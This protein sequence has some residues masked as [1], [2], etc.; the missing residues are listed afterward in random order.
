ME[1]YSVPFWGYL[2]AELEILGDHPNA[3]KQLSFRTSVPTDFEFGDEWEK[4]DE[5]MDRYAWPML[6][7][8]SKP[9]YSP[10]LNRNAQIISIT[11]MFRIL[12]QCNLNWSA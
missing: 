11:C 12:C 8:F 1:S 10:A 3:L 4:L 5:V 9:V 7:E 2:F 6:M